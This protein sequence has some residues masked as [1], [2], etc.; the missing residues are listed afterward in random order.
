MLRLAA[1]LWLLC[2]LMAAPADAKIIRYVDANGVT[3]FV[4]DES[5]VPAEH[6]ERTRVYREEFDHLSP[7]ERAEILEERRQKREAAE[8]AS[9]EQ[10]QEAERQAYLQSLETRVAIRNNQVLVPVQV[11]QGSNRAELTLLLDTGATHTVLHRD[12]LQ[13]LTF[14]P[15][16]QVL[17]QLAGGQLIK[18]E[19]VNLSYLRVG[20]FEQRPAKVLE[21]EHRQPG[22]AI[23]GLLGMDFLQQR[24]YQ[25]DYQ[26]QLIRWQP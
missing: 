23:H 12:A 10:R 20:P 1:S 9:R 26:H 7:K 5:R 17:S 4:D 3:V 24:P 8:A 13:G 22:S 19:L 16:R 15:G 18:S 11:G 14:E 21:I 2:A 6:R 25:I